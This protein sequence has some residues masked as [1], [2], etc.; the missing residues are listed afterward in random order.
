MELNEMNR[1]SFLKAIAVGFPGLIR[2]SVK[3]EERFAYTPRPGR[4]DGI[5]LVDSK[6]FEA[7]FDPNV[8]PRNPAKYKDN[9]DEALQAAGMGKEWDLRFTSALKERGMVIGPMPERVDYDIYPDGRPYIAPIPFLNKKAWGRTDCVVWKLMI[10]ADIVASAERI[11]KAHPCLGEMSGKWS[12][13]KSMTE[14]YIPLASRGR[15]CA[16]EMENDMVA[17]MSGLLK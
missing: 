5:R 14:V 1:R 10:D 2:A 4:W 13:E 17:A 15:E 9:L 11:G 12:H 6:E 16:E 8:N 7:D 3:G